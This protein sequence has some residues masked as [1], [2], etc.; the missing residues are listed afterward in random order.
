MCRHGSRGDTRTALHT[1]VLSNSQ[2][3]CPLVR[4][5]WCSRNSTM[6]AAMA[7]CALVQQ[8]AAPARALWHAFCLRSS[9]SAVYDGSPCLSCH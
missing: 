1:D 6:R 2:T 7:L 3:V 5:E 9:E 8:G 4:D